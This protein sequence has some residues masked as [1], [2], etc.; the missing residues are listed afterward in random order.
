LSENCNAFLRPLKNKGFKEE[1]VTTMR[2]D[3]LGNPRPWNPTRASPGIDLLEDALKQCDNCDLKIVLG[4]HPVEWFRDEHVP[5]IRAILG[6]HHALYLHG[7]LH[8]NRVS[9]EDGA[10]NGYLCVQ[11]GAAF[12]TRG[13]EIWVNG[14]LWAEL[15]LPQRLLRL[16]PREWN[17]DNRDWPLAKDFPERRKLSGGE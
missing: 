2:L 7:H 15:D 4:H 11:S 13:G 8:K 6:R 16:Q 1:R 5:S 17:P 3:D 12:Q 14:L 9:P 10:G